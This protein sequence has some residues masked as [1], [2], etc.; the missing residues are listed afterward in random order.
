MK[1]NKIQ[2]KK[3]IQELLDLDYMVIPSF[4]Y[5]IAFNPRNNQSVLIEYSGVEVLVYRMIKGKVEVF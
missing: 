3:K 1:L 4:M 5:M 2:L